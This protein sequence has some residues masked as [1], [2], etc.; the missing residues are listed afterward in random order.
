MRIDVW[1]QVLITSVA[2]LGAAPSVVV[3]QEDHPL[4]SRYEGSTLA[5]KKAGHNRVG[6]RARNRRVELVAR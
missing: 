4:G 1:I 2:V 5:S 6:D 3:G